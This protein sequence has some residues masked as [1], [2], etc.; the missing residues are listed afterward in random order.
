M[1]TL[2]FVGT[3]AAVFSLAG[4]CSGN[5]NGPTPPDAGPFVVVTFPDGDG[6]MLPLDPGDGFPVKAEITATIPH[7]EGVLTAN[8]SLIGNVGSAQSATQG[9]QV[10]PLV[11]NPDAGPGVYSNV[12]LLSAPGPG[13][14]TVQA[15]VAGGVGFGPATIP[16]PV[17]AVA[18]SL[19]NN[20]SGST[21]RFA[22]CVETSAVKGSVTLTSDDPAVLGGQS[23]VTNPLVPSK[24]SE[25]SIPVGGVDAGDVPSGPGVTH[26]NFVVSFPPPYSLTA[27]LVGRPLDDLNTGAWSRSFTVAIPTAPAFVLGL[28]VPDGGSTLLDGGAVVAVVANLSTAGNGGGEDGGPI[29]N[30]TITF[31]DFPSATLS[32]SS[33]T[34]DAYGNAETNV[35]VGNGSRVLLTA[36]AL[37]VTSPVVVGGPPGSSPPPS[38]ASLSVCAAPTDAG[39]G[40]NPLWAIQVQALNANGAGMGGVP[41]TLSC[42]P[43]GSVVPATVSTNSTGV[44]NA[45]ALV[46]DGGS[47]AVIATSGNVL[48]FTVIPPNGPCP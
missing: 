22:I 11:A 25:P 45:V 16:E 10:F 37:G 47:A 13:A 7:L 9:A 14:I 5:C 43:T 24:C 26:A 48:G 23:S 27:T 35:F 29:A 15:E 28:T 1:R 46:T 3:A 32:P 17:V 44:A 2:R 41:V 30:E 4:S 31:A 12:V 21:P 6:G 34:T 36:T 20:W 33:A 18:Y 42:I 8:V 39:V 40:G 38:L 19:T